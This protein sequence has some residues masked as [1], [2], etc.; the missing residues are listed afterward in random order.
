LSKKIP[1]THTPDTH[2]HENTVKLPVTTGS[3]ALAFACSFTNGPQSCIQ[4]AMAVTQPL[5]ALRVP[6][7]AR[8]SAVVS[9]LHEK[10]LVKRGH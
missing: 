6:R 9:G 3:K 5:W 8:V 2:A 7:G 1:G 4:I 10:S